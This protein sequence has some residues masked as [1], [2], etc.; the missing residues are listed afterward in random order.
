MSNDIVEIIWK[1]RLPRFI[2]N[3]LWLYAMVNNEETIFKD[4]KMPGFI[5]EDT[6]PANQKHIHPPFTSAPLTCTSYPLYWTPPF[7]LSPPFRSS[8]LPHLVP[9]FTGSPLHKHFLH[10]TCKLLISIKTK[11]IFLYYISLTLRFEICNACSFTGK[12]TEMLDLE[13]IRLTKT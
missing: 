1:F 10:S 7:F 11:R 4:I 13:W 9:A 8:V 5:L 12:Q 6:K 2:L 3:I